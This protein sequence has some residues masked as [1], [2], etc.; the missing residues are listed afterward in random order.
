M[1]ATRLLR[2]LITWTWPDASDLLD[3]DQVAGSAAYGV[4]RT[5]AGWLGR[6]LIDAAIDSGKATWMVSDSGSDGPES[7]AL[8]RS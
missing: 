6:F 1:V 5:T 7:V 8:H 3:V 4:P 2:R